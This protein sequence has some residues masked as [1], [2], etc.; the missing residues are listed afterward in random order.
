[1]KNTLSLSAVAFGMAM[2][3]FS[4]GP[5]A[6]ECT[7]NDLDSACYRTQM[8]AQ[9]QPATPHFVPQQPA[10]DRYPGPA[11]QS[12]NGG[13]DGAGGGGGGGDQ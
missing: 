4:V 9:P 10:P 5:R 11:L 2:I 1:M 7:S 12:E 6:A 3:L 8:A 13:A